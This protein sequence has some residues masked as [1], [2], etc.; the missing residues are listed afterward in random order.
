MMGNK[1]HYCSNESRIQ[2]SYLFQQQFHSI[3]FIKSYIKYRYVYVLVDLC[4]CMCDGG[5]ECDVDGAHTLVVQKQHSNSVGTSVSSTFSFLCLA[6]CS[7]AICLRS[8][9]TSY[10]P[11]QCTSASMQIEKKRQEEKEK[12]ETCVGDKPRHKK[13]FN[14][15]DKNNVSPICKQILY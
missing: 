8:S 14:R 13:T 2:F 1:I 11:Q 9:A 15:T 6:A 7:I 12:K 4:V 10:N 5:N 3:S